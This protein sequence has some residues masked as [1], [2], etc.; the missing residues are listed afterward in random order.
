MKKTD[1][2][3]LIT[4]TGNDYES[5]MSVFE[6]IDRESAC[7]EFIRQHF[8][9]TQTFVIE[10]RRCGPPEKIQGTYEMK[11]DLSPQSERSKSK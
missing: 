3:W 6:G 11:L 7:R 8:S 10:V 1:E 2:T 4:A 5:L 9:T